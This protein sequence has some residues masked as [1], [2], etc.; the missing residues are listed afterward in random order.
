MAPTVIPIHT[1]SHPAAAPILATSPFSAAI[2]RRLTSSSECLLKRPKSTKNNN[3]ER[4]ER[5][6][7]EY[8]NDPHLGSRSSPRLRRPAGPRPR[9]R[10]GRHRGTLESSISPMLE[11]LETHDGLPR[12]LPHCG[13]SLRG[14]R[15]APAR[16]ESRPRGPRL[17]RRTLSEAHIESLRIETSARV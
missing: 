7:H 16:S 4:G 2:K 8:G 15:R 12:P 3:L 10:R 11:D 1:A 14:P 13:R 9:W 6:H 17:H 5:C